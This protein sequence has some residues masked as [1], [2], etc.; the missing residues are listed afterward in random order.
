MDLEPA[1][2]TVQERWARTRADSLLAFSNR[3][4]YLMLDEPA[5]APAKR[6]NSSAGSTAARHLRDGTRQAS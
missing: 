6:H 5:K 3:L 4:L 2:S 1:R